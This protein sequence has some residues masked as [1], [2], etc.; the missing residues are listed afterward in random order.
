M[1]LR[2]VSVSATLLMVFLF[3]SLVLILPS[4]WCGLLRIN[5]TD[6]S[7]ME[8]PYYWE[9]GGEVKFE[10]AGGVVGILKSQVTSIQEV[11]ATKEFDPEVLLEAS[12]EAPV[13]EH[14]KKLQD[15]FAGQ[16]PSM[17]GY[18]KLS[19]DQS[20][21]VLRSESLT[22]QGV[23]AP[24]EVLYGPLFNLEASSAQLV[25]IRGDGIL[26]VM[27]NLLSSRA[28][29]RNRAFT[30][31]AYSGEGTVLQRK[32]CEIS[33]I[34]IDRKTQRNLEV[35]GHLFSVTATIKPD[36]RIKRFEIVA[37]RR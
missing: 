21:Q 7:F 27:Q 1:K 32:P 28:D 33:E 2:H 8:V 29:L 25:R 10:F 4:G 34:T 9:E 17:A 3:A 12:K 35:S 6:G 22:R 36:S 18:E 20:L 13:L 5:M 23:G 16:L 15:F 30:L 31:L 19:L 11:L 14:Q 26:L 24:K 37:A